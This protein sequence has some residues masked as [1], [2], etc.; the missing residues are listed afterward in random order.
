MIKYIYPLLPALKTYPFFRI[1]GNGLAN[2]MF[3]AARAYIKSKRRNLEFIEPTWFNISAGPYIRRQAD[4]RHYLGLFKNYGRNWGLRKLF[5][6]LFKRKEVLVESGLGKYFE[7]I[8]NDSADA[9]E[10]F[11][12]IFRSNILREI[13]NFDFS[14]AVAV[15][16]RLGDYSKE[17]RVPIEW[18]VQAIRAVSKIRPDSRFLLFSDGKDGELSELTKLGNVKRVFFG[19]AIADIVAISKT[20]LLI[21]SDSTFS[22]WGAYL[23]QVPVIMNRCHFGRILADPGMELVSG[24]INEQEI[25][26]FLSRQQQFT[27]KTGQNLV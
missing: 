25:E 2:C 20:K 18:Y 9:A 21:G 12:S 22:A 13:E 26:A 7:D 4:K 17:R 19:N 6:L 10:Y 8:L 14:G 16:V 15:H 11:N 23:G 3:V 1:A 5:I 24:E 27:C